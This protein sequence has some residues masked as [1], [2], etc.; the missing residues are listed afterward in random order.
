[1]TAEIRRLTSDLL[2][3]FLT[4]FDGEAFADNPA[5]AS[6]YCMFYECPCPDDEWARRSAQQNRADKA[7]RIKS[8]DSHGYLAYVE[9]RPV[10]WCNAAPR[11]MLPRID[12][13]EGL[14]SEDDPDGIGAIVCFVV[15]A[16]H[17][18]QGVAT[19]FDRCRVRR[20]AHGGDDG[21]GSIS[22]KESHLGRRRLSRTAGDV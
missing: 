4:F 22:R 8:S 21:G 3:D 11:P 18:K 14:T 2:D 17:R 6:C 10:A 15:A 20:S 19:R 5:W 9:G 1:M 13:S 16:A 12:T 7:E